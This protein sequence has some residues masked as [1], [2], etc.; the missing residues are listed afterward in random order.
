L[1]LYNDAGASGTSAT[2]GTA[3][4]LSNSQCSINAGTATV[5]T[6]GMNLTLNLPVTFTAAYAG[7]KSVYMYAAGS[8][9]AS[10][11]LP[12]GSWTVPVPPAAL[13]VASTHSGSFTQGQ[14]GAVYAVVVSNASGAGPTSGTVT[15]TDTLPGGLTLASTMIGTGG[16]VAGTV[17]R[18]A[19]GWRPGRAIQRLL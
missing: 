8:S 19:T 2:L 17:A 14:S 10:G 3:G 6:S 12:M 7:A 5:T 11:W 13:S 15:V 16:V 4:T 18:G 1:F 9:A